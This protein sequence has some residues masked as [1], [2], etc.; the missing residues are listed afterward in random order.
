MLYSVLPWGESAIFPTTKIFIIYLE[1]VIRQFLQ[2]LFKVLQMT[3][4]FILISLRN[5]KPTPI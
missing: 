1:A 3:C 2:R 5:I 4:E